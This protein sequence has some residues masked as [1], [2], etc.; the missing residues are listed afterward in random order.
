MHEVGRGRV[1]PSSMQKWPDLEGKFKGK[2]EG[3]P[4][5]LAVARRVWEESGAPNA[6]SLTTLKNKYTN[7]LLL[8][9]EQRHTADDV[10]TLEVLGEV[11]RLQGKPGG[12]LTVSEILKRMQ[13][14]T[15]RDIII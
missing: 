14:A 8:E 10:F 4:E 2:F 15:V 12:W 3:R 11:A 5:H 9:M 13:G 7:K 6:P 1:A